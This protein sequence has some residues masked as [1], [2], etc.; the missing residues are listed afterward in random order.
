MQ[1]SGFFF[2]CG[3]SVKTTRDAGAAVVAFG[4]RVMKFYNPGIWFMRDRRL[5]GLGAIAHL[6]ASLVQCVWHAIEQVTPFNNCLWP[7]V[8]KV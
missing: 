5:A 1:I 3:K 7:P 6:P 8:L 4:N 2:V